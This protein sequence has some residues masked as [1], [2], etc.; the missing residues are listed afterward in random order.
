VS[1]TPDLFQKET[2]NLKKHLYVIQGFQSGEDLCCDF[3][4]M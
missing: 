3:S 1:I 4:G 2:E